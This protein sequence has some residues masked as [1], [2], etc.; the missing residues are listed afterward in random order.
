MKKIVSLLLTFA[1]LALTVSGCG[2]SPAPSTSTTESTGEPVTIKFANYAVLEEGNREFWENVKT[3]FEKENP[4][5][6]IEWVSAP[7]GELLQQVI[8]MAGGGER[9]DLDRKSVV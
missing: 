2:G 4:D 6:T 3:N 5:I 1:M 7:F 9:V 8:N